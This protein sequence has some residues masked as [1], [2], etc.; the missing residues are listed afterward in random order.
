[1]AFLKY[2]E[3]YMFPGRQLLVTQ[4]TPG[5]LFRFRCM[6]VGDL[7][8]KELRVLSRLKSLKLE[9]KSDSYKFFVYAPREQ[10]ISY[11]FC[12]CYFVR[13]NM[14]VLSHKFL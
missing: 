3:L 11:T 12:K 6:E 7:F 10:K 9:K 4:V 2:S 8:W 5:T 14:S 1:M 13:S